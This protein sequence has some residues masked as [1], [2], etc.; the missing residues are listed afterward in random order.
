MFWDEYA[1]STTALHQ[2]MLS[3]YLVAPIFNALYHLTAYGGNGFLEVARGLNTFFFTASLIPI[4]VLARQFAPPWPA[5]ALAVLCI[6]GPISIYTAYFSPESLYFFGFWLFALLIFSPHAFQKRRAALLGL[7]ITALSAIKI[8]GLFLLPGLITFSAWKAWRE[9]P[10]K[11]WLTTAIHFTTVVVL[12]CLLSRSL[13]TVQI[14]DTW[15]PLYKG[16]AYSESS[17]LPEQQTLSMWLL[18]F[19]WCLLAHAVNLFLFIGLPVWLSLGPFKL[20]E[21][22]KEKENLHFPVSFF[23]FAVPVFIVTWAFSV[24]EISWHDIKRGALSL[25]ARYYNYL[26][27]LIFLSV[28]QIVAISHEKRRISKI[29]ALTFVLLLLLASAVSKRLGFSHAFTAPE[30]YTIGVKSITHYLLLIVTLG[31]VGIALRNS[32]QALLVYLGMFLPLLSLNGLYFG[33]KHLLA[34]SH[35]TFAEHAGIA[36]R[37][38][39]T[40]E[41]DTGEIFV[42]SSNPGY[43]A[44]A[45]MQ[46]NRSHVHPPFNATPHQ[47]P[48]LS[49]RGTPYNWV[50]AFDEALNDPHWKLVLTGHHF[51][52]YQR[53]ETLLR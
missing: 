46:I 35:F 42:Y 25:H 44:R 17:L 12:A 16:Y 27:P 20:L 11:Q 21:R 19:L 51:W 53:Q 26:F 30:F 24:S 40:Q 13:I 28:G 1:H 31:A 37:Q 9:L 22:L 49:E 47:D 10:Q 32:R 34:E 4:Y 18:F 50:L 2:G 14:A 15:N 7:G 5:L 3:N 36:V 52:L 39:L 43:V 23:T 29:S 6:M 38:K 48:F 8:H 33:H 41:K 45:G